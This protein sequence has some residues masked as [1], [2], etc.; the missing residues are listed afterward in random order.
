M[1]FNPTNITKLLVMILTSLIYIIRYLQYQ[2]LRKLQNIFEFINFD[3][4]MPLMN[5]RTN[6]FK[7]LL[8][9]ILAAYYVQKN[10]IIFDM[11]SEYIYTCI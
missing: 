7:H 1:T 8:P 9:F 3:E 10:K 11:N 6:S 2:I 4:S 5:D